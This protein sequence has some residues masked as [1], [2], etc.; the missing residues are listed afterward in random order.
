MQRPD[1]LKRQKITEAAAR[2][3]AARPFHEVRLD[4]IAADAQVG[5]GTLYIYFRGKE[6]L[7]FSIIQDGFTHLLEGLKQQVT[8]APAPWE[9]LERI[10]QSLVAFAFEYPHFFELMRTMGPPQESQEPLLHLRQELTAII[11]RT[12]ERGIEQG[13]LQDPL[14][15]LTAVFIPGLVRSAMLYGPRD[16][17]SQ[18]LTERI[19]H[20]LA[21]GLRKEER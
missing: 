3:F 14:P 11:G 6:D 7:Y 4:E 5:K 13:V 17:T 10:V 2:L 19:L 9:A 15:A 20:L 16:M 1:D 18:M 21:R 12:L 8:Q